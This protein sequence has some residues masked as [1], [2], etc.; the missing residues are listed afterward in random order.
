MYPE[1]LDSKKVLDVISTWSAA[2][3]AFN[4]HREVMR[5]NLSA[6]AGIMV[7]N[8]NPDA[9]LELRTRCTV[10]PGRNNVFTIHI[11]GKHALCEGVV[12]GQYAVDDHEITNS[13]AFET[14]LRL[15][16]QKQIQMFVRLI[17]EKRG[18]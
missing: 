2:I 7:D 1:E 15:G 14:T 18:R 10:L 11:E 3:E 5:V 9:N 8:L 4:E 12:S 6:M 17:E 13:K 16:L